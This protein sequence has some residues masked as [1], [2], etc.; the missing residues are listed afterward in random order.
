MGF[1]VEGA[2]PEIQRC[3]TDS[4]GE[5]NNRRRVKVADEQRRQNTWKIERDKH[6]AELITWNM[7]GLPGN[8]GGGGASGESVRVRYQIR[9]RVHLVTEQNKEKNLDQGMR[10][11]ME[12]NP[13]EDQ[14]NV[15]QDFEKKLFMV[16]EEF[17]KR[18]SEEN[19]I[20]LLEELETD[21]VFH[22]LE[23]RGILQKNQTTA[24]KARNT[25]DAVRNK[26]DK[27]CRMMI[28]RL[29]LIDPALSDQLGLG[30]FSSAQTVLVPLWTTPSQN[31]SGLSG[32][33]C[34]VNSL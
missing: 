6:Q 23:K 34:Y 31:R 30:L 13:E 29:Q 18:I 28:Q 2:G 15:Q 25:I 27:S 16:R 5:R 19:L 8:D 33:Q 24:D 11:K 1:E 32:G 10:V 22:V 12:K 14:Q 7:T 3:E 21:G 20:Q 9:F 26:G 17:V 4:D